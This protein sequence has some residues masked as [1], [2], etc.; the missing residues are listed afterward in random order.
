MAVALEANAM[1]IN[2]ILKAGDVQLGRSDTSWQGEAELELSVGPLIRGRFLYMDISILNRIANRTDV[3]LR[4]ERL[5]YELTGVGRSG[6]FE[7]LADRDRSVSLRFAAPI[8]SAMPNRAL[9]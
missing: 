3:S 7:A 5:R 8:R 9:P 2:V 6:A 4:I 1:T